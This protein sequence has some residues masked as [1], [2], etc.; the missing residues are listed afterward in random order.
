MPHQQSN[1]SFLIPAWKAGWSSLLVVASKKDGKE[2]ARYG[3]ADVPTWD[4]M[5]AADGKLFISL[6]NGSVVCLGIP[7][8]AARQ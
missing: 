5:S 4:G 6:K 3:L 7:D 1:T 8:R 2:L